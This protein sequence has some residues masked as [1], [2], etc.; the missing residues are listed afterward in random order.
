MIIGQSVCK[1]PYT[2]Q[3]NIPILRIIYIGSERSLVCL[4]LS[5]LIACGIYAIVVPAAAAKPIISV[6]VIAKN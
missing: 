2:S 6:I 5:V 3:S 1:S 4:L